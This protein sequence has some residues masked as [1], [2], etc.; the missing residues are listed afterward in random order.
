MMPISSLFKHFHQQQKNR[1]NETDGA[2]L[3]VIS[4]IMILTY[5]KHLGV[6]FSRKRFGGLWEKAKKNPQALVQYSDLELLI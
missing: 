6:T 5:I 1:S 2:L 4:K 3:R